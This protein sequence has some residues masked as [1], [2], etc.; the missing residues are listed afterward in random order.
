VPTTAS[1]I[2]TKPAWWKR[3]VP[4][5]ALIVATLAGIA[6]GAAG[7]SGGSEEEPVAAVDVR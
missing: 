2:E 4:V 7:S 3:S 6:L 1:D 5:W